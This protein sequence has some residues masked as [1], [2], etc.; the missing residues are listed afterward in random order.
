MDDRPLSELL[1]PYENMAIARACDVS[2]EAAR[3]WKRGRHV[4]RAFHYEKLA[5]F[6]R[7]TVNQVARA[8]VLQAQD[9]HNALRPPGTR[10][11]GAEE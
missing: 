4:P 5:S 9:H 10:P 8:C 3:L 11:A 6:L 2:K 7:L 1:E